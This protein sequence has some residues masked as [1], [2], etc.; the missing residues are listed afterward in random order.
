MSEELRAARQ[1][2]LGRIVSADIESVACIDGQPQLRSSLLLDRRCFSVRCL[3][4][5]KLFFGSS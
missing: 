3:F 5:K 2:G 1:Q 4:G